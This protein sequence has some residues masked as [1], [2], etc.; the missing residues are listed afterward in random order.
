VGNAALQALQN[1]A[2]TGN[3]GA[4]NLTLLRPVE[5]GEIK[6]SIKADA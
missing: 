6:V 5:R 4:N 1:A 2:G 3:K